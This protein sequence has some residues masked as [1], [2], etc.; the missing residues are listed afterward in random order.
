MAA[1]R[2]SC[3]GGLELERAHGAPADVEQA[4]HGAQCGRGPSLPREPGLDDFVAEAIRERIGENAGQS[5][6]RLDTRAGR[7]S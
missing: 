5:L 2:G 6:E 1:V 7:E 3:D 4:L